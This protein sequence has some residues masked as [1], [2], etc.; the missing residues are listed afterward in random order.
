MLYEIAKA[1][2]RSKKYEKADALL[3]KQEIRADQRYIYKIIVNF[4]F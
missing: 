1:K 2:A 4:F 3:H